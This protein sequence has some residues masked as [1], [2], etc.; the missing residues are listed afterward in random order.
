MPKSLAAFTAALRSN[1][2]RRTIPPSPHHRSPPSV[3]VIV[4]TEPGCSR[5]LSCSCC[6]REVVRPEVERRCAEMSGSGDILVIRSRSNIAAQPKI[7]RRQS[8]SVPESPRESTPISTFAPLGSKRFFSSSHHPSPIRRTFFTSNPLQGSE[9]A[10]MPPPG[11]PR[12]LPEEE[13][14]PILYTDPPH[15]RTTPHL[16][17]PPT[18][19]YSPDSHPFKRH[20]SVLSLS[21]VASHTHE[22]WE[23]YSAIHEDLRKYIPDDTFRALLLQQCQV[24][25]STMPEQWA[26]VKDL[27][28]LGKECDMTLED[29]GTEVLGKALELGVN[30]ALLGETKKD[31]KR[32]RQMW[33][34]LTKSLPSLSVLPLATRIKWLQLQER[35]LIERFK[36]IPHHTRLN[37]SNLMEE[38]VLDMV[39]RG[40]ASGV[41][42]WVARVLIRSRGNGGSG[43]RQTV[44]NLLWCIIKKVELPRTFLYD[45]VWG[46]VRQWDAKLDRVAPLEKAMKAI[47]EEV[48]A[49]A[50]SM[51]MVEAQEVMAQVT[52]QLRRYHDQVAITLAA[53][54]E[55]K[56]NFPAQIYKGVEFARRAKKSEE[57]EA[58]VFLKGAFR[59]F[60]ASL[61]HRD[62]DPTPLVA[63]LS[64]SLLQLRS[65]Y[66][67]T[68]D[69]IIIPFVQAVHQARLF[70]TLP[71]PTITALHRLIL[72]A[73]PSEDAYILSRKIYEQARAAE[74]PF[75]WSF[76]NLNYWQTLF[77]C[78]L[79]REKPHVHFASRLYT[80]LIADGLHVPREQAL[81]M[82][83]CVGA[84]PSPSRP[85]LLERHIK[86]YIWFG[87]R[88]KTAFIHAVVQGLT[89]KGVKDAELA[90]TLAERLSVGMG[91]ETALEPMVLELIIVNLARSS[92]PRVR[93]KC[94]SLLH[95]LPPE[96][97]TKSYNTVLSFLASQSRTN[98]SVKADNELSP[99]QVLTLVISIYKDMV[100]RGVARDGRTASTVLRTLTDNNL[101]DEGIKVLE[102]SLQHDIIPKSHAIGRL[103]TRLALAERIPEALSVE[104]IWRGATKSN[105]GEGPNGKKV[106][107][108]AVVGAR[109]L[110]DVKLG[111]EVDFEELERQTGWVASKEY[112]VFLQNQKRRSGPVMMEGE[113]GEETV[114]QGGQ[115]VDDRPGVETQGSG[116]LGWL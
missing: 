64:Q 99:R 12:F 3:A 100:D 5:W 60:E 104:E 36:D 26:R 110:V 4:P 43:P 23:I 81:L 106:W 107:D 15:P 50:G 47:L 57:E 34:A 115:V 45:A 6:R 16:P 54:D 33:L 22:S 78:A 86:D 37:Q 39:E 52:D 98:P 61:V 53:S 75:A 38:S 80:D 44:R 68:V 114:K 35:L 48:E 9:F 87:Y 103:M 41:E 13:R 74:P 32:L 18:L 70:L 94:I 101:L 11:V 84:K 90:L 91:Q 116:H 59:L 109:A 66:P 77:M 2:K 113:M 46:M 92:N 85:I 27:L 56:I 88:D 69:E 20:L 102:S 49:P 62:S 21:L 111:K 83:R 17:L 28:K 71:S 105:T 7:S 42:T 30:A 1:Q 73:L 8:S 79:T 76:K 31:R 82:L 96:T 10:H 63:S 58:T 51:A 65:R 67:E 19:P 29:M 97:A 40:G 55:G 93:Q 108:L 72:F 95:R 89:G 24:K 112:M 25:G 14:R